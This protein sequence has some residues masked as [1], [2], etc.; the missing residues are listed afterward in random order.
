M[1]ITNGEMLRQMTDE[2]LADI[3]GIHAMCDFCP[4]ETPDC[5]H[6]NNNIEECRKNWQ[7]WLKKPSKRG[8]K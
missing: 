5:E 7:N 1:S 2:E 3:F 8:R 4:A 6:G